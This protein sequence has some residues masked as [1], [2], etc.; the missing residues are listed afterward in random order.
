VE[1]KKSR[2]SP[3]EHFET[4]RETTEAKIND[5]QAGEAE[6]ERGYLVT[7]GN[8]EGRAYNYRQ[9]SSEQKR[10]RAQRQRTREDETFL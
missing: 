9:Y 6:D 2:P 8:R 5:I 10:K 7:N 1:K 4:V 3:R